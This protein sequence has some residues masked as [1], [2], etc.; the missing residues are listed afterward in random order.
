MEGHHLQVIALST[1]HQTNPPQIRTPAFQQELYLQ[2]LFCFSAGHIVE[3]QFRLCFLWTLIHHPHT[4]TR[5]WS[6]LVDFCQVHQKSYP[7]LT[8]YIRTWLIRA[9]MVN[10]LIYLFFWKVFS[11][12]A[13]YQRSTQSFPTI[14][15]PR[16][17]GNEIFFII[18]FMNNA[19]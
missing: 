13:G 14:F 18:I 8:F 17:R 6:W 15:R 9:G 5:L 12:F 2:A 3:Y 19:Y 11:S 10:S 16:K 4:H 7:R 1:D